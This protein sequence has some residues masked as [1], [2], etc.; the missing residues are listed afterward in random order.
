[1]AAL[2]Y[3][4]FWNFKSASDN[5]WHPLPNGSPVKRLDNLPTWLKRQDLEATCIDTA[6][7]VAGAGSIAHLRQLN[8]FPLEAHASIFKNPKTLRALHRAT[9]FVAPVILA[10]QSLGVEYRTLIPR[11]CHD[12]ERRRDEEEVR[13]HI[14]VGMYVGVASWFIRMYGLRWGRAYWAPIDVVLGGGLADLAHREYYKAHG[15]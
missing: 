4:F 5:D 8:L 6:P 9:I 10:C 13:T 7:F 3:L 11:W 15:L 14:D 2:Q 1:M 12:R